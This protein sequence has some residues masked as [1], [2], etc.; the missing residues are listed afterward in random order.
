ML[1][2]MN[3][4]CD[5]RI[6]SLQGK[7]VKPKNG[8]DAIFGP[9]TKFARARDRAEILLAQPKDCSDSPV[10]AATGGGDAP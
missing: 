5:K 10:P 6:R 7:N 3:T 9:Q 4:G 1:A 8:M 2:G